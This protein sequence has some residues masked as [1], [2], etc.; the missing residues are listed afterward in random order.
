MMDGKGVKSTVMSSHTVSLREGW[1]KRKIT[2]SREELGQ[3]P[4]LTN[5]STSPWKSGNNVC[6]SSGSV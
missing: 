2:N 1:N 5:C 4:D 6:I 3:A